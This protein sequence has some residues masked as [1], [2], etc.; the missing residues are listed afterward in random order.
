MN[1][2]VAAITSFFSMGLY[3]ISNTQFLSVDRLVS[4]CFERVKTPFLGGILRSRSKNA[5]V[6]TTKILF[7]K[8]GVHNQIALFFNRL[9]VFSFAIVAS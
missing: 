7:E 5:D 8:V 3:Q 2:F 9:F 4:K 1:I 6:S